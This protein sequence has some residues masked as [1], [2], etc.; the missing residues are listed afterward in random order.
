MFKDSTEMTESEKR[1]QLYQCCD[2]DLGDAIIM[3]FRHAEVVNLSERELLGII[4]QLAVILVLV[5]VQILDFISTRQ[6]LTENTRSFA[7]RL[8]GKSS[9]CSY[10]CTCLI[11][12]CNQVIDF[13]DIILKYVSSV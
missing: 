4:K 9:T 6:D 5:V 11:D 2:E 3:L 10:I 12:G 8:K 13:T 1:R 7:T